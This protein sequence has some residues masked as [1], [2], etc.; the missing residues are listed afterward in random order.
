MLLSH[1]VSPHL[2]TVTLSNGVMIIE[3]CSDDT[4][5]S[6]A[7]S[8]DSYIMILMVMVMIAELHFMS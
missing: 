8:H 6:S 1:V 3:L 2:L 7:D 5:N 4:K